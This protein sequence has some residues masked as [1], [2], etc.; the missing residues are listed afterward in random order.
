MMSSVYHT[1]GSF[2]KGV[3]KGCDYELVKHRFEVTP[4]IKTALP[5]PPNRFVLGLKTRH[6]MLE[7]GQPVNLEY[8]KRV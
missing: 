4:S 7:L 8:F 6:V 3:Y 1:R 2:K 5:G